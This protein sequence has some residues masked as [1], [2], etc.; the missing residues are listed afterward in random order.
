[1]NGEAAAA[2][3]AAGEPAAGEPAAGEPTAAL[4]PTQV[5]MALR[6]ESQDVFERAGV[7]VLYSGVG[8]VNA[9]IVLTRRLAEYVRAQRPLPL[10]LNFGSAGSR[11][12]PPGTFVACHEFVQRDMDVSGL[13]FARGVTPFEDTP[14]RLRFSPL[15]RDLAPATCA[16]GDSF[17][18]ADA[19]ATDPGEYDVVDMEAYALAKVCWLEGAPFACVKYVTDGADPAAPGAWADNV[20]KAA[21]EFLRLY[22]SA[23]RAGGAARLDH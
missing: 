3:A 8:K 16:S 11:R 21:E 5:I 23:D 20:H 22:R 1:L 14:S 10:V 9:A 2:E 18:A 12:H 6:A 15:F 4:P 13:G 19:Q 17:V 7:P